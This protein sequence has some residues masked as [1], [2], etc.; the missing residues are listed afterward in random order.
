M[1]WPCTRACSRVRPVQSVT[2]VSG[3]D[4]EVVAVRVATEAGD[5]GVFNGLI[6]DH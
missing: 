4:L 5:Q 6:E 3:S 1:N 2:Y